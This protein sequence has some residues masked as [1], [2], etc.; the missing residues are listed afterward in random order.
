[1]KNKNNFKCLTNSKV[2]ETESYSFCT[3]C[4]DQPIVDEDG[5]CDICYALVDDE[6]EFQLLDKLTKQATG[7]G[8]LG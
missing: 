1:M 8:L 5:Y 3:Q 6:K 2:M 7:K 4:M